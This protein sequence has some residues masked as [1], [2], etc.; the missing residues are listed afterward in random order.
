MDER[1]FERRAAEVFRRVMDVF[2]DIDPD[3]AD[4]ESTGDVIRVDC[5]GGGRLVLNTQRPT[6]QVW[7][8]GGTQGYHFSYDEVTGRWLD[9]KG[10]GELFETV[11]VLIKQATGIELVRP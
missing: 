6:R 4:V 10:R 9:D 5:R 2:E 3:D 8:A 11:A 1:D 7:L